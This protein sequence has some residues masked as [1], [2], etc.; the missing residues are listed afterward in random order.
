MRGGGRADRGRGRGVHDAPRKEAGARLGALYSESANAVRSSAQGP[1][2]EAA[3]H[4]CALSYTLGAP[5]SS[6]TFSLT[7]ST[8]QAHHMH[9]L[10]PTMCMC[11]RACRRSSAPCGLCAA[12]VMTM[13]EGH[14][15]VSIPT[16]EHCH[17]AHK[18]IPTPAAMPL[19]PRTCARK[20]AHACKKQTQQHTCSQMTAP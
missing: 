19:Y 6:R 18:S 7:T 13:V 11:V 17:N 20:P 2:C 10:H 14:S 16:G 9:R 4:D 15:H 8:H 12:A 5:A 1:A 3:L